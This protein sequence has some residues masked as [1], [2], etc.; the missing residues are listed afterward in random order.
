[1]SAGDFPFGI[2]TA[3]LDAIEAALPS[4][5]KKRYD[6]EPREHSTPRLLPAVTLFWQGVLDVDQETGPATD[7]TWTWEVRI[8]SALG[9]GWEEAQHEL[10]SNVPKVLLAIRRDPSLGGAT[11][12]A[13]LSDPGGVPEINI[14][15]KLIWKT[16]I[17]AA[18][19]KETT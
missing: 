15:E 7:V 9:R 18:Q 8:Y 6:Y 10:R 19:T 16:L 2:E 17:L 12:W 14:G 5:F 1:M 13:R 4:L 3:F 11:A